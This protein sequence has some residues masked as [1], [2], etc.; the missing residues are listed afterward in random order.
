MNASTQKSC[1][2]HIQN[3][4]SSFWKSWKTDYFPTL[5]SSENERRNVCVKDIVL[6][7]NHSAMKGDWKVAERITVFP[8]KDNRGNVCVKYAFKIR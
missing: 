5:L 2:E 1:F 3:T 6:I 7:Q 8:N 4:I